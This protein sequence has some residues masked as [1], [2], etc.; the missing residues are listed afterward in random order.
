MV[1]RA[2]TNVPTGLK[3]LIVTDFGE[4]G[5]QEIRFFSKIGFAVDNLG[6]TKSQKTP[7]F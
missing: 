3:M 6:S 1:L 2:G 5:G 7:N 4:A